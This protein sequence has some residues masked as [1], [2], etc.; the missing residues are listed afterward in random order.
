MSLTDTGSWLDISV[1]SPFSLNNVPFGII[2]TSSS[3][4]ARAAV[5]IGDYA[6]DL[7]AF[8]DGNGFARL[9]IIRDH[10]SVFSQP[11]LNAFASL[12]RPVHRAVRNYIWQV[13]A[14]VSYSW[15]LKDKPALKAKALIPRKDVKTHLPMAIGDYTDFYAGLNH[16]FTVGTIM[17][18]KDNALQPNYMHIPVGYHS[19]ASSVVV[20]GTPIRRPRGQILPYLATK[21]PTLAPSK[22][23]DIE[24]ELAAFICK[25]NV[26]GETVSI[27]NARDYIFGY[28]L[29]NDWSA[30]DIQ[31]WE[32]VP[33]GPFNSKNFATTISAWVVLPDALE[34]YLTQGLPNPTELQ[35][36]LQDECKESFFDLNLEVELT[37]KRIPHDLANYWPTS[38]RTP[39]SICSSRLLTTTAFPQQNPAR[40]PP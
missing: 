5:A 30:R 10:L 4:K 8:A 11:T 31:A 24:L 16:A 37:S 33:L 36:Y 25:E 9:P 26:M 13:F 32:Y 14:D 27:S 38:I 23:L 1:D 12:G 17:R 34:P 40:K 35:K 2:S 3:P 29:M 18:G 21:V 28:V 7:E 20:S 15:I 19:R 39:A 22:R 6:L